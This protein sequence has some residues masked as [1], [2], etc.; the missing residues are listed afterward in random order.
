[1]ERNVIDHAHVRLVDLCSDLSSKAQHRWCQHSLV[2]VPDDP[3]AHHFLLQDSFFVFLHTSASASSQSVSFA[4]A[5]RYLFSDMMN[6]PEWAGLCLRQRVPSAPTRRNQSKPASPFLL[7]LD[8]DR[9]GGKVRGSIKSNWKLSVI[10][11][12]KQQHGNGGPCTL[13]ARKAADESE[14]GEPQHVGSSGRSHHRR[15]Q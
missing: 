6:D 5:L 11:S 13:A 15:Q 7:G 10:E 8:R 1:M 4:C 2:A 14:R 9:T 3:A 12:R